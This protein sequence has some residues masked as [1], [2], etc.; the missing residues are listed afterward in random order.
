MTS[1]MSNA[2]HPLRKLHSL[3]LHRAN[4]NE[5][6]AK[7]CED[8]NEFEFYDGLRAAWCQAASDCE[9]VMNPVLVKLEEQSKEIALL[10]GAL[11]ILKPIG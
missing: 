5:K 11:S 4:E 2:D 3:F 7:Q 6:V 1:G 10:R 9:S 8:D